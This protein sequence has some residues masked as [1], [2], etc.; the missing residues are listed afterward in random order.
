M[1]LVKIQTNR[2]KLKS[3]ISEFNYAHKQFEYFIAPRSLP[4]QIFKF[5]VAFACVIKDSKADLILRSIKNR[6]EITGQEFMHNLVE[7]EYYW[8]AGD[9]EAYNTYE[10]PP[11]Q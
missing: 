1:N 4:K 9:K 10:P 3:I 5:Y 2:A 8:F 11:C 7:I 6:R